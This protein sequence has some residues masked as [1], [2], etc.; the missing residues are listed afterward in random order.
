M[1]QDGKADP[2]IEAQYRDALL[3]IDPDSAEVYSVKNDPATGELFMFLIDPKTPEVSVIKVDV[4]AS[5]I[6][7]I[8]IDLETGE[9]ELQKTITFP[10]MPDHS[11]E[12]NPLESYLVWSPGSNPVS[13]DDLPD[14]TRDA[15]EKRARPS[16]EIIWRILRSNYLRRPRVRLIPKRTKGVTFAGYQAQML[17]CGAP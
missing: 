4:E 14:A 2:N 17:S 6:S 9:A 1:T 7:E 10:S 16:L 5:E 13:L 11:W 8:K 15:L 12:Y 3:K